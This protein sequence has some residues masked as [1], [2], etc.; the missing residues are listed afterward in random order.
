MDAWVTPDDPPGEQICI[1]V[2]LP[3]GTEYEACLKGAILSLTEAENWEQVTGETVAVV[4]QA[5]FDAYQKTLEW[6]P[7]VPIGAVMNWTT[8]TAPDGWL[9]C[10]G[11]AHLQTG[12]Y[13]DLFAVI[14]TTYGGGGVNFQ[15]P[16]IEGRFI[17]GI[18]DGGNLGFKAGKNAI[19]L[20]EAQLPAHDHSIPGTV[21]TLND[22]PVGLVPILTPS[23][24]PANTGQTGSGSSIDIKP[25]YIQLRAII[26]HR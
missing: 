6:R 15:L 26:R 8:H 25:K 5:F 24:I 3:S 22:I 11:S 7:C 16:D 1:G 18:A 12:E 21:P 9:F 23:V 2:W 17:R 19:T 20:T 4:S 13:A 10:D 14:G